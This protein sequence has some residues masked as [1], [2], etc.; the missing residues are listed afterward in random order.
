MWPKHILL[1]LLLVVRNFIYET[2]R[3]K[4]MKIQ[5]KMKH[6]HEK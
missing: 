2:S 6:A 4:T 1:L 3:F 5:Y